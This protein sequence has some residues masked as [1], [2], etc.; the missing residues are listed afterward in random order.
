MVICEWKMKPTLSAVQQQQRFSFQY[1]FDPLLFCFLQEIRTTQLLINYIFFLVFFCLVRPSVGILRLQEKASFEYFWTF[2]F[3]FVKLH[4]HSGHH[5]ISST[6][7][8]YWIRFNCIFSVLFSYVCIIL[9][10]VVVL[11][12]VRYSYW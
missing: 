11:H 12:I 1:D 6:S 5:I 8:L 3:C 2:L 7:Y 4:Y 9:F 10:V